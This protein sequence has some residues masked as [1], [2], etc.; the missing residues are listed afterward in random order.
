MTYHTVLIYYSIS[1]TLFCFFEHASVRKIN[2]RQKSYLYHD[3][4]F[5]KATLDIVQE[6]TFCRGWSGR[7][8]IAWNCGMNLKAICILDL[9]V[10]QSLTL[11]MCLQ[12]KEHKSA[13]AMHQ[14]LVE[15]LPRKVHV[16]RW[17]LV[18]KLLAMDLVRLY[19]MLD[20]S[21][22]TTGTLALSVYWF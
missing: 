14:S 7:T 22:T 11:L 20:N 19:S 21:K 6:D 12:L 13:Q 1:M 5:V 10:W 17:R 15:S 3:N 2:H 16:N 18:H 4:Y 8:W 9:L